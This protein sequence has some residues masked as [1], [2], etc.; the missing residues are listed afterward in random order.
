[1]TY[2]GDG[3]S[4]VKKDGIVQGTS[5]NDLINS[6]Y[7][8]D[9]QGD[10]ID[11]YDAI[12]PGEYGNDDIVK[13][14]DGNDTVYAGAG[15]DEVYGENGND[16][17]SGGSGSNILYGGAGNDT[18]IGGSGADTFQGGTGQD[19]IDY[20]GSCGPVNVNLSTGTLTGGDATNDSIAGGVDGVIGTNYNDTLIGFDQQGT[21]PSDTYTNEFYGGAGRDYIDGRGGDDRLYGGSGNDTIIGGA[22]ADTINGGADRDL[23]LGGTAGDV[24]DGGSTGDD[25][26]TLDLRGM[27]PLR[28]T[29]DPSNHENGTVTFFDDHH[30]VTGTMTF[31]DI[32]CVVPCFTPGT[33]VATPRG[34]VRVENLVAGDKVITR[35]NGLQTIRWVGTKWL[36]AGHL[37]ANAHL[38]PILIRKGALGNDLPERDM[39]VSPNHRMLVSNERTALYFEEHEVLVAA[40][41]LIDHRNVVQLES[42][43][44]SYIHFMMDR[45]EVVLADGA[46]TESFQPGDQTLQGL[47][48]AQRNEIYEL[49]PE[50]RTHEGIEEYQSARRTLRRHEA[51]LLTR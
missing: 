14:G 16:V 23:I 15:N 41:H 35:D 9:P 43:G 20:S 10:R 3:S 33:L 39:I 46:W 42:G 47:G 28:V 31:K 51:Q 25:W 19:N 13:A 34:E 7:T 18:F 49:F 50:L 24:V 27:G 22:G 32:E 26:D 44:V 11:N 12:L 30:H 29:Y 38:Q 5:G 17:L 21:D 6:N 8:G 48:N 2:C 36:S 45:H 40:K 1:M 37:A 4:G